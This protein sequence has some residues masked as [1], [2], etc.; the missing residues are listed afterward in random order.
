M[1]ATKIRP[2]IINKLHSC[3]LKGIMS[4]RRIYAPLLVNN[5]SEAV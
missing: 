3:F 4:S 5:A 1:K 2:L